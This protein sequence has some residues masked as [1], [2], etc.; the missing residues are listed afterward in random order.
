MNTAAFAAGANAEPAELQSGPAERDLI[1]SGGPGALGGFLQRAGG[2]QE[3][4]G[5][6]S[7]VLDELTPGDLF[8]RH[9]SS[10]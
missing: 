2:Q 6:G 3:A 8:C 5:Q 7:G 9:T 4:A 1:D 10:P